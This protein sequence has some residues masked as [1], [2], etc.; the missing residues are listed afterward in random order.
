VFFGPLAG[1]IMLLMLNDAVTKL[2]EHYG[3]VL[4]I[5]ILMFALGLR[6]GF[7]DYLAEWWR[8]RQASSAVV[9]AAT[10]ARAMP[11][12]A[13]PVNVAGE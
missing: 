11:A 1:A 8:G 6:K 3:L 2:T 9:P 7:M 10:A 12:P 13:Q 4:G 5:I